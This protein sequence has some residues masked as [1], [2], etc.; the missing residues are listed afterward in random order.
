MITK[1]FI[2]KVIA[3]RKENKG[4]I[5]DDLYKE[6]EKFGVPKESLDLIINNQ[7]AADQAHM[8]G[9]MDR[10]GLKGDNVPGFAKY[11][12][13]Q[14]KGEDLAEIENS[15][16]GGMADLVMTGLVDKFK[17]TE[18][19]IKED[20][21]NVPEGGQN[22]PNPPSATPNPQSQQSSLLD[23]IYDPSLGTNGTGSRL[24]TS[25]DTTKP[26]DTID[27]MDKALASKEFDPSRNKHFY[28]D[29][30][31]RMVA[32]QRHHIESNNLDM[33]QAEVL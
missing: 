1:E 27:E 19:Y 33:S 7:V 13:E 22:E 29:T 14:Y 10:A 18:S 9:L 2:K 17:T 25:G 15:L 3:S 4:T 30:L 12:Q 8:Q 31:K 28:N 5:P 21:Q 11:L 26:F 6:A 16:Q 23:S 24:P 32:T 20:V